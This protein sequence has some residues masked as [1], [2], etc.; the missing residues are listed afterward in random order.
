MKKLLMQS[1]IL[2]LLFS[3]FSQSM[4]F[5]NGEKE[6]DDMV[7]MSLEEGGT[8]DHSVFNVL[9][10]QDIDELKIKYPD[11]ASFSKNSIN[12][13]EF[14][15]VNNKD[16]HI[17]SI[18]SL[19]NTKEFNFALEGLKEGK[20]VIDV[21]GLK[22]QEVITQKQFT[23]EF[24]SNDTSQKQDDGSK[25]TDTE[26]SVSEQN[27]GAVITPFSGNLNVDIDLSPR[28]SQ[29]LSGNNAAYDLV[30]K[31]TGSMMEYTNAQVMVNLPD[32]EYTEF[33]QNLN[34][35]SI[36]G[37]QPTYQEDQSRLVYQF[38]TLETGQTYENV[39]K[40]QTSN[41]IA[42]NGAELLANASF[43]A[44][45]Q[46]LVENDASITVEASNPVSVSKQFNSV[47]GNER[48]IATPDDQTLWEINVDIPNSESG[49]LYL[50]E[51]SQIT[52]VDTLPDGL[53]YDSMQSGPEPEQNGNQLIWT[54]DAPTFND[55]S[56]STDSLFNTNLEVVLTTG[57]DTADQTL[58]NNV[59][60]NSMF[61]GG[62][63]HD[64]NASEDLTIYQTD[65]GS[66][67]VDGDR[68]VPVH[69]GPSNGKGD[70]GA[71]SNKNPYPQVY[72][73]ALLAFS[74]GIAPLNESEA[75]DFQ[76]YTT[77]YDVDENLIFKELET[78]GGFIYRPGGSWPAGV[79]LDEEPV[80]NIEAV[81]DGQRELLVEDAEK[82][83][84]YN[85]ADL[86]IDEGAD[87]SSIFYNFTTAPSGML[88]VGRPNYYFEIEEGYT[89]DVT[90][91]WDV[92]GTDGNGNDF[93]NQ[94]NSDPLA[95]P[96]SAEI[97]EPPDNEPPI[98][99]VGVEL[100]DQQGSYITAGKNRMQ[101]DLNTESTSTLAMNEPMETAVLMP[102]GVTIDQSP[103]AEFID[104]DG[105]STSDTDTAKGGDFE[106]LSDDYNG[107]GR[108]L[109][110]FSWNDSILRPG[111][112][113]YSEIN[114]QVAEDAPNELPFEVYGFSGD[115]SLDVPDVD[116]PG[117]TDTVLQT[118]DGDLNENGVSDEPR[119]KSGNEYHI[120]GQYD[121]QTEKLVQGELDEN[122]SSFGQT[123]PGGN[124]DY[125]LAL[126]NVTGKDISSMTM[127]DVLPA[128]DDLGI[129]DNAER[130]S[131]FTPDLTGEI[132]LPS[133]W[134]DKVE[135]YYSTALTPE[136]DDLIR[137]TDY[138]DSTEELSNPSEAENP[139]WTLAENV[140][141]WSNIRS[142]KIEMADDAEWID[143]EEITI[144]FS[145]Q[146]P[147]ASEVNLDVLDRD[148]EPNDRAAWNSFAIATDQGQPVE[149]SRVGVYMNM[150]NS[151]QLNKV[152]EDQEPLQ[153]AEFSL[154]NEAGE[155]IETGL[156][157]NEEGIITVENLLPGN[158]EFVET[159][160][161]EGYQLNETPIEFEIGFNQQ[162]PLEINYQNELSTGSVELTKVGERGDTLEGAEFT[163]LD[164]S[165]NEME[166]GLTTNED[167][168]LVVD[169]LKPGNYTFV[170]TQAPEGYQLNDKPIE[171]EVVFNQQEPLQLSHENLLSPGSVE[172]T[173][174]GEGGDT[175]EGAE[176]TLLDDSEN[177]IETGL[178][179]DEEGVLVVDDLKP[180]NYAFIETKAPEGYQLDETP[181]EFEIVFNQQERLAV[182]VEN[183]YIPSAFNLTK[184]GE[185]GELLEGV[186][187]DLQNE[188]GETIGEE[189]TTD[190][191][192][193]L[194]IDGLDP[195][196]YQ[197]IEQETIPGYELDSTPIE[198]EIGLGQSD[199]T[200]VSFEN[201]LSPGSVELTKVGEE[202]R[203][204]DGAEFTLLDEAG[205]E[206]ETSLTTN[207]NGVLVVDNLKPGNYR[208]VETKAPEG[209]QLNDEPID[210]EIVFNQQEPLQI[211]HEN[212]LSPGSVQLTKLGEGGN[213]LEGAEFMLLDDSGN[214]MKTGL[215]TNEDGLLVVEDLKPGNY[216][217]VE[218]KAPDGYQLDET[219]IE[220][221]IGVNQQTGINLEMTNNLLRTELGIEKVDAETN[222]P[223]QGAIFEIYDQDDNLID[224]VTTNEEGIAT[225]EE[226]KFGD[227]KIVETKAPEGYKKL[228]EPIE[229]EVGSD[230]NS[231]SIMVENSPKSDE[232]PPSPA[233]SE[234]SLPQT[235]QAYN[236]YFTL[237]GFVLI[238]LGSIF[239][240]FY[241][242]RKL[243]R[244]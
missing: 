57:S 58:T 203:T 138:P 11:H 123:T 101:V 228:D 68:Y 65:T 174:E 43:E 83:A 119:I 12:N 180:G 202:G 60:V 234:G 135:V 39:I 30:F 197:L 97:V 133:S 15:I 176:F 225:V 219:P 4:V 171:F 206:I 124:I 208:F 34:E 178:T 13:D 51:N 192:G 211:S 153:G 195:G 213:T 38:D 35:L 212:L 1:L 196:S 99:T 222:Q 106:V 24:A 109:V 218:T 165:G 205:E 127:I 66:G 238:G 98:A 151:V 100:L 112:S 25:Q 27:D 130:G 76:Q 28:D 120:A 147:E 49:Q 118:D 146:A 91:T 86:G 227:Y 128:V 131:Q 44:D 70:L 143:G 104:A 144:N 132:Q 18:K 22:N 64:T 170:E 240:Y 103:E 19:G 93:A 5:A 224:T 53:S 17:L 116:D 121:I 14:K 54:F 122:F 242:R 230:E 45:Q 2:V 75:G 184:T 77:R 221:E 125:K 148:I 175:L 193:E 78:P 108:Q 102:P 88:N 6:S 182:E 63:E 207:E 198:F 31:T 141:D 139:N 164:D 204:L 47:L 177:E 185:D 95:G 236:H 223:L 181:I 111:K 231:N 85:R 168:L 9:V 41:G 189:L 201:P 244:E 162:E 157:T 152:D 158:Y 209:Y 110:Q 79:P 61:V 166:T 114:V 136:R 214:E 145:M 156:T 55:Q 160:A 194:Y 23:F 50:E 42:P 126:T 26:Q 115:E 140:T 7:L 154:F 80:F 239:L 215:T 200:E 107:S 73:D 94:Y 74:H 81:V 142:F 96:R 84:V 237:I 232:I 32:L 21:E 105:R 92:Y 48:N 16:S 179:T 3:Q 82:G 220:F 186:E 46:D 36:A 243:K 188:A 233:D 199:A 241:Y 155:E 52:V 169:D 10:D 149:P 229:H 217:F 62:V 129:T 90:N 134:E 167:G 40:L 33:N 89:G 163:L 72:D 8:I 137:N 56:N 173:K 113:L 183:Q 69:I 190:E 67:D 150:D 191:N 159:Q 20:N 172:L 210:F 71:F 226:L 161:P 87:V 29:I 37:V 187:F 59:D 117:L 216:A 235:N